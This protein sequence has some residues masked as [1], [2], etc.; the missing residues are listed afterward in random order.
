MQ[1]FLYVKMG[2]VNI[3][4]WP[5][6]HSTSKCFARQAFEGR[7]TFCS[8]HSDKYGKE[9]KIDKSRKYKLESTYFSIGCR[10]FFYIF[11]SFRHLNLLCKK[12]FGLPLWAVIEEVNRITRTH[13]HEI[14]RQGLQSIHIKL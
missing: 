4:V 10:V 5:K 9:I 13:I 14:H 2:T 11:Q 1:P 7:Y 3:G 8:P 12:C 6:L